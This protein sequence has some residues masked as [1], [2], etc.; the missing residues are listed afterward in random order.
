MN[1]ELTCIVCPMGCQLSV[2][3]EDGK[4]ISVSGNTCIRGEKYAETE[5]VNPVRVI[6]TTVRAKDGRVIAVKTDKPVPKDKIFECMNAI[7]SLEP[8]AKDGL[9]VGDTLC[10]DILGTGANV[11]VTQKVVRLG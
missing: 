6:T 3:I 9:G 10:A 4:V 11:V 5:C 1:R 2:E 8:D 7:N